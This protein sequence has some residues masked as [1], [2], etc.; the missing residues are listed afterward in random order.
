MSEDSLDLAA[1]L[2]PVDLAQFFA[3]HWEL[4]PL[5]VQ[6][7]DAHYYDRVLTIGD[8]ENM[9]ASPNARYPA[10]QL[11]KNGAYFPPEVYSED[12][13]LGD[14]CFSGVADVHKI[15]AEYRAGATIVMPALHQSWKPLTNLCT[16]I[17]HQLDH[18]VHANAY[19]T[20]GNA[21]GF[22]PHYDTHEVLVLQIAG[23]KR[24]R[25]YEPPIAMPHRRQPFTPVGHTLPAAPVLEV[26]L[27][28]GD[29]LYLPRGYIHTTYTSDTHSAHVT[30]GI[31]V[32]TWL[33]LAGELLQSGME[34]IRFRKALPQALPA[35]Q[36]CARV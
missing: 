29:L 32:Y 16:S 34:S 4:Q 2:D 23:R 18:V 17:E 13:K 28:P 10:I 8:L 24:W 36:S 6:G 9:I 12:I 31:A 14:V 3:A 19:L 5:H 30:L 11:S 15:A 1:L 20:P 22:A 35:A 25:V 33:N 7:R 26:D 27:A 21:S